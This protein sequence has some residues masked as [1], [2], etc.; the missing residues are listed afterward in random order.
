[1]ITK[2]QREKLKSI[3]G[4]HYANDVLKILKKR[5]ITNRKGTACGK[6]MIQ[7]VYNGINE[8]KDIKAAI[9]N[10]CV[11]KLRKKNLTK[12][13]KVTVTNNKP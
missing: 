10:L 8:N 5:A 7:N 9:F 6:S 11:E 12:I 1:M 4:Y 3:L 2:K 13:V